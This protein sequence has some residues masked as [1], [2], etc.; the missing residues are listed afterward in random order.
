M[1]KKFYL[2]R[3]ILP[4]LCFC[5]LLGAATSA[6]AAPEAE[7]D[8][9]ASA[10]T[11]P[12][13]NTAAETTS[14]ASDNTPVDTVADKL[15]IQL[16]PAW[17]GVEFELHTD[18]GLYP[19]TIVVDESGFLKMELGGSKTYT[20]SCLNSSVPVPSPDPAATEAP[21]DQSTQSESPDE[22]GESSGEG[23]TGSESKFQIPPMHLILFIGG[24]VICIGALIAMRVV[25]KRREASYQEDEDDE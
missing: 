21:D 6:L 7:P 12:E 13:S 18:Y 15:V 11:E 8:P 20:I 4:I 16:G 17:A 1:I 22:D 19:G 5:L 24:M 2:W 14:P 23:D 3:I 9:T 25:R 10:A